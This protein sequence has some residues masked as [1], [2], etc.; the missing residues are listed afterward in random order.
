MLDNVEGK[1]SVSKTGEITEGYAQEGQVDMEIHARVSP[2]HVETLSEPRGN[3]DN[4]TTLQKHVSR[5]ARGPS[6]L[7]RKSQTLQYAGV[8]CNVGE[9]KKQ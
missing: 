3:G 8:L 4:H 6:R 1:G 5:E 9:V 2:L 7:P